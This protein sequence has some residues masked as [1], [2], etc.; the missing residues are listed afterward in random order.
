MGSLFAVRTAHHGLTP[1]DFFF[2][3]SS[4]ARAILRTGLLKSFMSTPV[5]A[6]R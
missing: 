6:G 1:R 3:A 5:S 2:C 4:L